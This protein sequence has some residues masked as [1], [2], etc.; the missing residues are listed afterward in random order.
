MRAQRL[1]LAHRNFLLF[2]P[3]GAANMGDLITYYSATANVNQEGDVN[4]NDTLQGFGKD[5]RT[6]LHPFEYWTMDD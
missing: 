5:C 6:L 4:I 3:A 2:L 1:T